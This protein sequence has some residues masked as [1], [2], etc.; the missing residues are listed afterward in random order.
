M[1]FALVKS[2]IGGGFAG[3][4]GVWSPIPSRIGERSVGGLL[5]WCICRALP[6]TE[7]AEVEIGFS[8]FGG[9]SVANLAFDCRNLGIYRL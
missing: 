9:S 6:G 5:D 8:V 4:S 7:I 3:K 1:P 2:S